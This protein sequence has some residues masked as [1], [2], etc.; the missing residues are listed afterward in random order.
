MKCPHCDKEIPGTS[1]PDCG[2]TNPETAKYCINCGTY[3]NRDAVDSLEGEDGF[4]LEDRVLCPDGTCTGIIIDGKC[5]DCGK[6]PSDHDEEG[7][8]E[9]PEAPDADEQAGGTD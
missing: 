3:L 8:D 1:C 6:S 5:T 2:E 9:M 7:P 4:G